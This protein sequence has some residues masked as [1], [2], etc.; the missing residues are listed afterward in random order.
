MI[1]SKLKYRL[2]A[3][4]FD[5]MIIAVSLILLAVTTGNF[6][7][8]LH[9]FALK[10]E[11]IYVYDLYKLGLFFLLA[12]SFLVVYTCL[13]PFLNHGQGIGQYLFKI[14]TVKQ[15]GEDA[16]FTSIFLREFVI[17]TMLFIISLGTSVILDIL[18]VNYNK[19][20]YSLADIVSKT[21]VIDKLDY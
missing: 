20:G 17:N 16:D 14:R 21:M 4:L 5:I 6:D 7:V 15:N 19:E 13:I 1:R 11:T 9:L 3:L 2:L 12:F 8:F 18:I 10:D